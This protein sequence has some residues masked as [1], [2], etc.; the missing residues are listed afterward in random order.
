M[1]IS[2]IIC[3]QSFKKGFPV[4]GVDGYGGEQDGTCVILSNVISFKSKKEIDERYPDV[5]DYIQL[6]WGDYHPSRGWEVVVGYWSDKYDD[7]NK[8]IITKLFNDG[9]IE[10]S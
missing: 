6:H 10:P 5:P 1:K 2:K 8:E 4:L 3:Q 7:S 9:Y